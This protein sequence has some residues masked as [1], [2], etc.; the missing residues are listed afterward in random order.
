MPAP[1]HRVHGG[2]EG[3][4][5]EDVKAMVDMETD[6]RATAALREALQFELLRLARQEDDLA[7]NESATV[8]YWAPC[9]PSV[10]GHRAAAA[11][12]R[13]VAERVVGRALAPS[14]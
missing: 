2:D 14:I 12:L 7:C 5:Q 11:A 10:Q 3:A 6:S 13:D 4:D 8:P 9:P 1:T